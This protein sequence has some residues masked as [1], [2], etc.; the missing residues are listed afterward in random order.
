M[1]QFNEFIYAELPLRPPLLNDVPENDIIIRKGLGP[2]QI[3]GVSIGEGEIL[4]KNE[5]N[6]VGI[7]LIAISGELTNI[8]KTVTSGATDIVD[9]VEG[10]SIR[11]SVL[12]KQNTTNQVK[13]YEIHALKSGGQVFFT[14]YAHLGE[15]LLFDCD[16]S[17]NGQEIKFTF[18]N[19][20]DNDVTIGVSRLSVVF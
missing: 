14:E 13:A 16:I 5:G 3:D 17:L 7:P 15:A 8:V 11:W 9:Q 20:E 1:S 4:G 2:R 6:I 18:T 10:T 19:R 12:I